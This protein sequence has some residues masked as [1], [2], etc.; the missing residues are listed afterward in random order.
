MNLARLI[1]RLI[2]RPLARERLRTVLTTLAVAL[3]VAVV[4]A[5]D[6]AGE[7]STGSFQSSL[8]TLSGP[9]V[10][11]ISAIGGVD[12][13][14]MGDLVRLPYPIRFAAR[15]EDFAVVEASGERVP[16]FGVDFIGDPVTKGSARKL[17]DDSPEYF[18]ENAALSA[19][20]W[21]TSGV[22]RCA[23][24]STIERIS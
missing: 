2:G 3:G 23:W 6:L 21:A 16:L 19:A 10:Y 5:I 8:E 14:L 15:M 9:A 18:S 4:V 1:V 12:E 17:R 22:T 20:R 11:E 13:G 7:A 24:R